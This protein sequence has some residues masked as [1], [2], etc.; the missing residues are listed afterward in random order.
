MGQN[1]RKFVAPPLELL[2][3]EK[4][5]LLERDIDTEV[6]TAAEAVTGGAPG[7]PG[8]YSPLT[9]PTTDIVKECQ[10]RFNHQVSD[11][12]EANRASVDEVMLKL[13]TQVTQ[14]YQ[15]CLKESGVDPNSVST[16]IAEIDNHH[17]IKLQASELI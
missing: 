9:D 10:M 15:D 4:F 6:T 2:L 14:I 3:D 13:G 8:V 16:G 12:A 1:G 11:V 17:D 5:E 7:Q